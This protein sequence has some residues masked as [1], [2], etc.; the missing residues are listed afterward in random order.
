MDFRKK[1]TDALTTG[2]AKTRN[3]YSRA[4][5]RAQGL[6]EQA[7]LS[8]EISQLGKDI[9]QKHAELGA[10]VFRLLS[11]PGRSSVSRGTAGVKSVFEELAKLQAEVKGKQKELA[12][13]RRKGAEEK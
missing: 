7:L 13:M 8:L 12:A 11:A 1:V 5:A 4:R 3:L 6:S 9:E 10:T 2:A